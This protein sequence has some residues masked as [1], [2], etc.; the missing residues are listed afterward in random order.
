LAI[1]STALLDISPTLWYTYSGRR[2]RKAA[3]TGSEPATEIGTE[4]ER[5]Q[6]LTAPEMSSNSSRNRSPAV[7]RE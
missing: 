1:F 3:E 4:T 6:V 5:Q 7:E 2:K